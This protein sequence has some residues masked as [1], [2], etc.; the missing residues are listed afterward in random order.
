MF[1]EMLHLLK[2]KG[3]VVTTEFNVLV[4]REKES[5]KE[6]EVIPASDKN[7]DLKLRNC[8]YRLIS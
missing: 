4:V 2:K 7:R 1:K 3:F 5:N 8:Y 6:V